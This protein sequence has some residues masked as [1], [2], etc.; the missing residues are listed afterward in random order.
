MR[1]C[2]IPAAENE[3]SEGTGFGKADSTLLLNPPVS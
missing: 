3:W 1:A 2:R